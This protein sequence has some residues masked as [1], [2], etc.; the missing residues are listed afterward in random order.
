MLIR[1]VRMTFA[2][3]AVDTFLERFDETAPQIR[4]FPGCRHLELW[5]DADAPAVF[6]THSHWESEEALE[7][8][9]H[10]DL[11]QTTWNDVKPL[12]D[13]RPRAHSYTVARPAQAI[14]E[15]APTEG[16]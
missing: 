10:S 14:N 11:F 6:T 16:R 2:P 1:L 7:Q 9:R 15:A 12:F 8:Y 4:G 5:R 3:E 13:D